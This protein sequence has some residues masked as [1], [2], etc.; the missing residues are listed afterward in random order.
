M[1]VKNSLKRRRVIQKVYRRSDFCWISS[2]KKPSVSGFATNIYKVL[3][4]YVLR[5]LNFSFEIS[6]A[7][8]YAV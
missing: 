6:I 8:M 3:A 2:N 4:S 1:A 7:A 5:S